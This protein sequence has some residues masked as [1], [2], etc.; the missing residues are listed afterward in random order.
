MYHLLPI[1]AAAVSEDALFRWV[2]ERGGGTSVRAALAAG[3]VRGLVATRDAAVGDVLLEVPL[4]MCLCDRSVDEE[5]AAPL[6]FDPPAWRRSLPWNV[7]LALSVHDMR[8]ADDEMGELFIGSWPE[9]PKLPK[10]CEPSELA[11]ASDRSLELRA[12]ES[13]FWTDEQYWA[14]RDACEAAEKARRVAAGE[15]GA[16]D[17]GDCVPATFPNRDDFG[18]ALEQVW[19]RC[20]KLSAGV[21]GVR[22]LL[23]P[24]V[25]LA[26]HEACPSAMYAYA[27]SAT[28]GPAV[29]LH[30]ARALRAG[31]AVTITYGEHTNSHFA[32]YYGFV[33]FEP[34]PHDEIRLS[35][36]DLVSLVGI[37]PDQQT[38]TT[39]PAQGWEAA[40]ASLEPPP[41]QPARTHALRSAAPARLLVADLVKLLPAQAEA[42]AE[43]RALRAIAEAASGLERALWGDEAGGGAAADEA[44]LSSSP[45]VLSERG[46]LLVRLR[47]SRRILLSSLRENAA[48]LARAFEAGPADEAAEALEAAHREAEP[49]TYP[50][51]DDLPLE[52][53]ESWAAREWVWASHGSTGGA[54]REP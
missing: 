3:G 36:A 10:D 34:N 29:R 19:S 11:L 2:C 53:L 52:E 46:A 23:V 12:D 16:G 30:A 20:L 54:Y 1:L 41:P 35:L 37:V 38:L 7:Q 32:L 48:R 14:A 39:A 9:P 49:P 13:Y 6:P 24:A 5:S 31:D 40:I 21:H 42:P 22:R 18:W 50:H 25:D 43:A 28:G 26:N 17:D 8:G 51:L 44:L 45:P 47:L 15:V 33:P 27:A 4:A